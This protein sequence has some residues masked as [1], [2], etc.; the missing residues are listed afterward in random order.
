[1]AAKRGAASAAASAPQTKA[2]TRGEATKEELQ[3][4]MDEARESIA[5]TVTEIKD[6]VVEQYESVKESV[7]NTL[8]WREQ[9]RSHPVAWSVG[10][11]SVG[12]VIGNSIAAAWK[13]DKHDDQL[14]SH[15][16]ALGERFSDELSKHGM[17]ILMPALT[18]TVLV[19]MLPTKL[20]EMFGIDL[21]DLPQQVLAQESPKSKAKAKGKKKKKSDGAKKNGK[22]KKSRAE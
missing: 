17:N 18:G 2:A 13:G 12:Y 19:P 16:A 20:N 15:L 9:F 10:A 6:T 22:K 4:R 1:M 14:L 3:E 8:D 5:E 21:S 11:L 7:A